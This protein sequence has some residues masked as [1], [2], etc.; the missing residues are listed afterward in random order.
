[1]KWRKTETTVYPAWDLEGVYPLSATIFFCEEEGPDDTNVFQVE[2][3]YDLG[4]EYRY[5][6]GSRECDTFEHAQELVRRYLGLKIYTARKEIDRLERTVF[7]ERTA[8]DQSKTNKPYFQTD[9]STYNN[10]R[11][12][13]AQYFRARL[14][15]AVVALPDSVRCSLDDG[16]TVDDTLRIRL[17]V[18]DPAKPNMIYERIVDRDSASALREIVEDL[19][20]IAATI[21]E[22]AQNA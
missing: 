11:A 6:L 8:D 16:F 15:R 21:R 4:D 3:E 19:Q 20:E 5:P 7:P 12:T 22:E 18:P 17:D 9:M 10:A 14:I 2:C 13:P 1:M